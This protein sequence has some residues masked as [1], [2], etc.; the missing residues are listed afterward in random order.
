MDEIKNVYLIGLGAIGGAYAGRI[1]D[2]CPGCLR[3]VVDR[4][5]LERYKKSG[6]TI[7]GNAVSF[8]FIQSDE[9]EEA[10]DLI[11]IAVKQHHLVQTVKD[12]RKLV[13][14]GTTILSLLNGISSEELLGKEYGMDKLL[15]SFCVGTDTV[16]VATDINFTTIGKIVFGDKTNSESSLRV[17]AVRNFFD[18]AQVPYSIPEDIIRELWWK[19]MMNVGINQVSA[20]L[21]APYGPIMA[22]RDARDLM[23]AASREVIDISRK[24]GI[25]LSEED[26]EKYARILESLSPL[27]K[28][29]MLQDV[30]AGRKTEVEIFSGTV[31]ELGLKYGIATPVNCVLFKMLKAIE[32][33]AGI[34]S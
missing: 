25:Y 5:R 8:D 22:A 32:Q 17:R 34:R 21:R 16:R 6:I 20:V 15:Y 19:Y 30:E 2:N 1:Q 33:M 12:I 18:K 29:S 4:D 28:T 26:L 7:N 24:I 10:A 13:G 3:I 14:P 23:F 31:I 9:A 27:G 11:I